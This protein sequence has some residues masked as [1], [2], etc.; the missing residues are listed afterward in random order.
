M[1]KKDMI[2]KT[3]ESGITPL[4]LRYDVINQFE[5]NKVILRSSFIIESLD[6]GVLQFEQYRFVA[7]R[8]KIG[9]ELVKR[10]IEKVF[11]DFTNIK[12][13][14]PNLEC[15]SIPITPRMLVSGKVSEIVAKLLEVYPE[16]TPASICIEVSADV[17]YED[18]QL[19]KPHF[20]SLKELGVKIALFELGDEYCPV[21][22]L[23]EL[24]LNYAFVDNYINESLLNESTKSKAIGLVNYLHILNV[25]VFV[26]NMFDDDQLVEAKT[27]K[28]DGYANKFFETGKESDEVEEKSI[29]ETINS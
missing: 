17:L 4:R 9:D 15:V 19:I 6:L 1:T 21:F 3:I 16:I 22:R 18:T 10:L 23:S 2:D 24:P 11:G 20:E 5:N 8:S 26:Q 12:G 28:F 7:R 29:A 27:V 14:F 25:K 13:E